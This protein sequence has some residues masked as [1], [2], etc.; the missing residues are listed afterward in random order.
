MQVQNWK[1]S[2]LV[3]F[4]L[5]FFNA[6]DVLSAKKSSPIEAPE[7]IQK[8]PLPKITLMDG[9]PVVLKLLETVSSQTHRMG[10]TVSMAV[11][12]DVVVNGHVVI[13]NNTPATA[14]VNWA[15]EKGMVGKAGK[16]SFSVDA[17]RAVDGTRIPLKATVGQKGTDKETAAVATGII[18]CPLFLMMK[19]EE[20]SFPAGAETKA[21]VEGSFTF[22]LDKLVKTP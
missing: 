14:T 2:A 4:S 5:V 19:G 17:T 9:T 18:C 3:I 22:T 15:E 13:A 6:Q 20:A 1:V 16:I 12:Q 10:S 8:E 21:Y 7:E 11:A